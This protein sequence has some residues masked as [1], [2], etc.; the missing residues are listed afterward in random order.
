MKNH[1]WKI[2]EGDGFPPG[3]LVEAPVFA[4]LAREVDTIVERTGTSRVAVI[5]AA[6]GAGLS[7]LGASFKPETLPGAP[8][9][10]QRQEDLLEPRRLRP[11]LTRRPKSRARRPSQ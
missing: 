10:R 8:P 7:L 3:T 9:T 5:N 11:V 6:L 1:E 4:V 2:V